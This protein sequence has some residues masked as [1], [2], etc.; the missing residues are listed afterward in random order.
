MCLFHRQNRKFLDL[1]DLFLYKYM[2][3]CF[4]YNIC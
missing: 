1:W 4:T 2:M 3:I